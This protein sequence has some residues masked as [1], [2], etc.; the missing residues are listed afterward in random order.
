MGI[1]PIGQ[2]VWPDKR[3]RGRTARLPGWMLSAALLALTVAMLTVDEASGQTRLDRTATARPD[4]IETD[5][6]SF[7][8]AP[9]TTG[10][11][12][13]ILEASY[14]FIDNRLGPEAHS[15]PELLVRRGLGD[16]VELRLGF[17]YEAGGPGTV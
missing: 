17:N 14:S 13:T 3:R 8:F 10:S 9:T 6:D 16:K 11:Q 5:R 1:S 15:V 4:E 7:T 12:R 2:A